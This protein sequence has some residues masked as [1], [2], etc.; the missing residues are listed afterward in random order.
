MVRYG[1]TVAVHGVDIDLHGGKVPAM[2]GRNDAELSEG[3]MDSKALAML[4]GAV[5]G[6]GVIPITAILSLLIQLFLHRHRTCDVRRT[7]E[8]ACC[9]LA[10]GRR[11]DS[12]RRR[13]SRSGGRRPSRYNGI[14]ARL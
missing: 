8:S 5:G 4:G 7:A 14:R 3:G 10:A 13:G 9:G 11:C 12:G 6:Q 2:M 1:R